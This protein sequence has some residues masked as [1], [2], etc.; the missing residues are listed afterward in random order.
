M[1]RRAIEQCQSTELPALLKEK[2]RVLLED[3]ETQ[4]GGIRTARIGIG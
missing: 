3:H 4:E 1:C 2:R